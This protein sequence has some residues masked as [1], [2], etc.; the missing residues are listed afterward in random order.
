MAAGPPRR[1][2]S[3][4]RSSCAA[5]SAMTSR[6]V[7]LGA[8]SFLVLAFVASAGLASEDDDE[9][10]AIDPVRFQD[11][12]VHIALG[13]GW[14][15]PLGRAEQ[16]MPLRDVI[17]GQVPLALDLS[18][19]ALPHVFVGAYVGWGLGPPADCSGDVRCRGKDVRFGLN[20]RYLFESRSGGARPAIPWVGL[21]AGFESLTTKVESVERNYQGVS[22]VDL[23]AGL[24]VSLGR[25]WALG[26]TMSLSVGEFTRATVEGAEFP[27]VEAEI[28]QVRL[29]GW[30]LFGG[31]LVFGS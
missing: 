19:R 27:D 25:S 29:H 28:D 23:Q 8:V 5:L 26:P 6:S 18:F 10:R 1:L 30:A 22:F 13:S 21:G 15:V 24:D 16:A 17:V 11:H 20:G 2:C 12:R 9:A 3:S 14:G 4:V 31:R 7:R